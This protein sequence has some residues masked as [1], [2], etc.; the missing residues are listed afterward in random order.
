MYRRFYLS[1][2]LVSGL[3]LLAITLLAGYR[4][5]FPE[6]K[7]W[8]S[9]Y[10][11]LFIAKADTEAMKMRAKSLDI[12]LKQIYL[13]ELKRVDR[14]T[15]CHA[16][17]ENPI[18]DDAELPHKKHTGNY[19][20]D[21]PPEEFGCSVCH[22][23]QGRALNAKEA[24]GEDPDTHW[25]YPILPL[26]FIESS[27][28][29]CHDYKMLAHNNADTIVG[30][31]KLFRER[32]CQ[33]CHKVGRTG[34]VL[35]KNLDGIG[36]RRIAYFPMEYLEGEHTS[37]RWLQEHFVDPRNI[38]P[39]S[40][41]KVVLKGD[42]PDQLTAYVLTLRDDEAPPKYRRIDWITRRDEMDGEAL[43]KRYCVACHTTGKISVYDEVL[44]QTIPAIMNPM[45][46]KAIDDD[47]LKHIIEEGRLGTQMTAWKSEAAG[48]SADEIDKLA[49][50]ITR[51]RSES[52]AAPFNFD[53]Y[54][55]NPG[56][57][58]K[59]YQ[60]RCKLCHGEKGKAGEDLLGINLR[61]PIV[62]KAADP[63]FLAIT[64]RDGRQGTP[65]V[66]FGKSGLGLKN[67]DI[68]DLV[69]FV[70]QLSDGK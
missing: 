32:G 16:G 40:E 50:Y 66:A 42:E 67:Q 34:G 38:V 6:W 5:A 7:K 31:E 14:C 36:S 53:Q 17:V 54:K 11:D 61:N 2:A 1:L 12:G 55:A 3:V 60:V 24:H 27:C 35:G 47:L 57:G 22:R 48:L 9:E 62:Q 69:A 59:L 18:M 25:D 49:G 13:G 30:G 33:G 68:A 45:F 43:Y 52:R 28:A 64:I 65:M 4:E 56:R 20:K 70:R 58:E 21:H 63:D 51:E 19:L 44:K 15:N 39:E 23:G 10:K 41:M 46:L 37:Y 26:E 8:Q 29:Y